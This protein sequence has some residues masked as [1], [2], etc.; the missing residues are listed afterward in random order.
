MKITRR[1][2]VATCAGI[3]VLAGVSRALGWTKIKVARAHASPVENAWNSRLQEALKS[4]QADGEIDYVFLEN[5]A[6]TD[7]PRALRQY[8]QNGKQ[9]IVGEAYAVEREP[10][11][12]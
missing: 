10:R 6:N 12:C 8:T 1:R 7:Y 5:I 3:A 4:A 9:L 2:S 11:P